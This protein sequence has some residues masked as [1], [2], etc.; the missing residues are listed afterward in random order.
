MGHAS[1]FA[2][3]A[4][5]KRLGQQVLKPCCHLLAILHLAAARLRNHSQPS[6]AVYMRLQR[7]HQSLALRFAQAGRVGYIKQEF[8][9]RGRT[10]GMLAARPAAGRETV[11]QFGK[12]NTQPGVDFEMGFIRH[13]ILLLV[14]LA[15]RW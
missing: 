11:V 8:N 5:Y 14:E 1:V 15:D 9:P 10:V 13:S 6:C 2:F 4:G 12:G 3:F 7:G